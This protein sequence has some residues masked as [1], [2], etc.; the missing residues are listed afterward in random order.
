[1]SPRSKN[2]PHPREFR[3]PLQVNLRRVIWLVVLIVLLPT[4]VLTGLGITVIVTQ[5]N[6]L[7]I[8]LGILL[9]SFAVSVIAG[10]TLSIFLAGRG[11][12]IA[13][14][15]STFLSRI[16]HE[17]RT[18]LAGIHLHA[19]ILHEQPLPPTARSSVEA[20]GR[21]AERLRTLVE[22]ILRWREVRSSKHLYRKIDTSVEDV[23]AL[24]Y[25]MIPAS[26]PIEVRVRDPLPALRGDPEAL[27][28]ALANLVQNALKYGDREDPCVIVDARRF[29]RRV[30]FAVSDRGPGLPSVNRDVLFEPFQRGIDTGEDD[31]GGSGL[32]LSIA[33]QIV[34]AHGGRIAAMDRPGGGA[35]VLILLP[36]QEAS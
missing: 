9:V 36:H 11:A 26:E 16:S 27:A 24:L 4:T 22:R 1:V 6:P 5:E 34:R 20:I 30:V 8:V 18:P 14:L 12:R 21:E 10:A 15:Q 31:P 25:E 13:K 32:G 23:I 2:E 29:G 19:Q 28:E 3:D 33:R 7:D 35:R 17:L